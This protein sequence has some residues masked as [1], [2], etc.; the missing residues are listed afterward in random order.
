MSKKIIA[1]IDGSIYARSVCDYAAWVAGRSRLP[2][3][4]VHILA[5]QELASAPMMMTGSLDINASAVLLQ[6]LAELDE[7]HARL[8]AERAQLILDQAESVLR[9]AG[10]EVIKPQLRR[11]D[12]LETVRELEADADLIVLGKRGEGAD[13]ARLHLG[14]NF[15]RIV[16][17]TSVPVIVAPRAYR[18]INRVMVAFDNGPSVNAAIDRI[19]TRRLFPEQEFTLLNVGKGGEVMEEAL[20]VAAGKL[21]NAGYAVTTEIAAGEPDQV[22]AQ[23][24]V[25]DSIDLLVMGAFGKSRLRQLFLGSTATEVIRSCLIPIVVYH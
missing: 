20:A 2:V 19:A 23:R 15:D 17:A 14:S 8:A 6:E 3:E 18:P 9:A 11:G 4:P 5:R 10:V 22:I 13:F 12:L 21:R 7:D 16:R 25:T 1:L 24:V